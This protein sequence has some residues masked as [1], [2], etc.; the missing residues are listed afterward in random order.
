MVND[1]TVGRPL[2]VITAF[3]V[4]LFIGNVFQQ[5]Y[6]M[7]D[8]V[9]VGRYVGS[10]ALA[11]GGACTGAFNLMI[12]LITGLTN[13]M[14][15][16]IAQYFGAKKNDMVRKSFISSMMV[17]L[18]TGVIFTFAGMLL[19]R[20]LLLALNTPEDVIDSAQIYLTIM[21]AGT[22]ANC[23]YNGISAVLRACLLYTSPS[24]RDKRQ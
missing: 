14:G 23:L 10:N 24:P 4:P 21:F 18:L 6:N 12:A 16:V 19:S 1:M 5:V 2:K 13:G 3:A 7:V 22:L 11:A 17:I 15:V 9:V 20:P 8:S